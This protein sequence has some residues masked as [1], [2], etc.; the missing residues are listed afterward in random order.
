MAEQ[1]T[2]QGTATKAEGC[3]GAYDKAAAS[4]LLVQM[5]TA[6]CLKH[7]AVAR[8]NQLVC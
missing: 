3:N 1:A 8:P 2:S 4:T 7:R 5:S 6:G